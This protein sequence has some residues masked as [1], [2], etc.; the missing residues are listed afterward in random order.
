MA[1]RCTRRRRPERH[2]LCRRQ[3]SP[4][5]CAC[6]GRC[7]RAS[8]DGSAPLEGIADRHFGGQICGLRVYREALPAS[9]VQ[10][11]NAAPPDFALPTYEE[12]SRHWPVQTFAQAGYSAPQ[13]PSTFPHGKGEIQKPVAKALS[14]AD[15][16]TELAGE[17][18]W[19]FQ[20]AGSWPPRPQ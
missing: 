19:T 16:H 13:D 8:G 18:P 1:F 10:S 6:T 11:I 4:D 2:P 20:A 9:R 15:L 7:R 12:A 3:A 14:A 17:N 5:P